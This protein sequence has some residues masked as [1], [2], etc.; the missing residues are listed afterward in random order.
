MDTA[1]TSLRMLAT[2]TAT[3]FAS[4]GGAH[5][6]HRPCRRAERGL[7]EERQAWHGGLGEGAPGALLDGPCRDPD[8]L[9][10]RRGDPRVPRLRAA[11]R[12]RLIPRA[13][14]RVLEHA[15]TDPGRGG[16]PCCLADAASL[17][18]SMH[19]P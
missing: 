17:T 12:Q 13:R 10:A 5:P 18:G 7:A 3:A 2:A 9:P 1:R 4:A 11:R 15:A 8:S 19:G 16:G 14:R 6:R